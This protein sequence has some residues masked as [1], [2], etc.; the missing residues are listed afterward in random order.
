M[1]FWIFFWKC[2]SS[3]ILYLDGPFSTRILTL[4]VNPPIIIKHAKMEEIA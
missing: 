1:N 4:V 2:W 3:E